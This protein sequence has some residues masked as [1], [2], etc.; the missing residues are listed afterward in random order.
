MRHT[1]FIKFRAPQIWFEYLWGNLLCVK[2]KTHRKSFVLTNSVSECSGPYKQTGNS[3]VSCSLL[4]LTLEPWCCSGIKQLICGDELSEGRCAQQLRSSELTQLVLDV[5]CQSVLVLL[6]GDKQQAVGW[7]Q[8][9]I[10]E[11]EKG[12]AIQISGGGELAV[13]AQHKL[14]LI[15]YPKCWFE[16][17]YKQ[18]VIST[19]DLFYCSWLV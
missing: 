19:V 12:I 14:W 4:S 13:R 5:W 9:G 16:F 17:W 18:A 1:S 7:Y 11:L 3:W 15:Q 8:R 6:S 10:A 2:T